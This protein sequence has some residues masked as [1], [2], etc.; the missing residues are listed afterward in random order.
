MDINLNNI[1]ITGGMTGA[2]NIGTQGVSV[3]KPRGEIGTANLTIGM[4]SGGI[5]P[6]EPVA[7][8]PDAA[9]VR[10]DALGRLVGAAFN[11]P[12]P[13]MPDFS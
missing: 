10:D 8:I 13:A 4:K 5:S 9:L 7:N 2:S 11:L 3:D 12:P 6:G 1:G